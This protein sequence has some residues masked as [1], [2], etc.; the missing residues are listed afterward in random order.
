M[1]I[2][3]NKLV[4]VLRKIKCASCRCLRGNAKMT[5]LK[6]SCLL[7]T[8]T[9]GPNTQ[10][11]LLKDPITKFQHFVPCNYLSAWGSRWDGRN[12]VVAARVKNATPIISKVSSLCAKNSIYG[13]EPLQWQELVYLAQE[14]RRTSKMC[15]EYS[16]SFIT[17]AFGVSV[18]DLLTRQ[19]WDELKEFWQR[20]KNVVCLPRELCQSID[21]ACAKSN[22]R[23]IAELGNALK[24][25]TKQGAENFHSQVE[26]QF[27]PYLKCLREG[28]AS[29]INDQESFRRVMLYLVDQ[30]MRTLKSEWE[31]KAVKVSGLT[32]EGMRRV[33]KYFLPYM[34][35]SAAAVEALKWNQYEVTFI[36]TGGDV[37]FV[38]SDNPVVNFA[39]DFKN[40]PYALL[41]PLSPTCAMFLARLSYHKFA[42]YL[43]NADKALVDV[44]N[45]MVCSRA[46]YHVV[47]RDKTALIKNNYFAGMP[48]K[49]LE[50]PFSKSFLGAKSV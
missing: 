17:L 14:I 6:R 35:T 3:E 16:E 22:F 5:I 44:I 8:I 34:A 27:W 32:S 23:L 36:R 10:G 25:L 21:L 12:T 39:N 11:N 19:K 50:S 41:L 38:T 30:L 42:K 48:L 15:D 37:S 4:N 13:Y 46:A 18:M 47:S 9:Q 20:V 2:V 26:I 24:L 1:R 33:W 49:D 28:C 45:T 31:V 43:Q 29:C 40:D 7:R